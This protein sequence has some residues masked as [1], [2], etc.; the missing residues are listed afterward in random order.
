MGEAAAHSLA[1]GGDYGCSLGVF[2]ATLSLVLR[3]LS[4][5]NT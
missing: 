5:K 4:E 3:L 2:L 1:D